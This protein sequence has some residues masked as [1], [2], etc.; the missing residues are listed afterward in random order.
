MENLF[1]R[2]S[3][4]PEESQRISL[5]KSILKPYILERLIPY[6]ISS[7]NDLMIVSR[8]IEE[9]P[10]A[11]SAYKAPPVRSSTTLEP[12]FAFVRPSPQ[13]S[14]GDRSGHSSPWVATV[15]NDAN[16]PRLSC[17]N[18]KESNHSW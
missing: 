8:R 11:V 3:V 16:R 17:R 18:C 4:I 5:I 12:D 10:Q 2:L 9:V 13:S 14:P 1:A 7:I 15:S 6:Q